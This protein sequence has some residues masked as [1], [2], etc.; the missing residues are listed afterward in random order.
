MLDA[1]MCWKKQSR[2]SL[3]G[4]KDANTW[5]G[6]AWCLQ[7]AV[8]KYTASGMHSRQHTQAA[9]QSPLDTESSDR[10]ARLAAR[11]RLS[12]SLQQTQQVTAHLSAL[13][14]AREHACATEQHN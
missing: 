1:G 6:H 4:T 11:M 3:H 8:H 12:R 5:K 10:A 7:P 14:K 2:P 13:H 9:H